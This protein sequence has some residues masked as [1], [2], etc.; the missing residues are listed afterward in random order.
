MKHVYMH[1]VDLSQLYIIVKH[2]H[3]NNYTL[4]YNVMSLYKINDHPPP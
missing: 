1:M 3:A 2:L 4:A